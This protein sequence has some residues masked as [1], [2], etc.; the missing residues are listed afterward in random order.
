MSGKK[1]NINNI[2]VTERITMDAA[3]F[4]T[5]KFRNISVNKVD[6]SNITLSEFINTN[7]IS[8]NSIGAPIN[9]DHTKFTSPTSVPFA[10][11]DHTSAVDVSLIFDM[12]INDI[13]LNVIS[14][15]NNE[16]ID[17]YSDT[18]FNRNITCKKDTFVKNIH[19]NNLLE[20]H[21]DVS[22]NKSIEL[23]K[24][25]LEI[26]DSLNDGTIKLLNDISVN[27]I[28]ITKDIS[29]NGVFDTSLIILDVIEHFSENNIDFNT[30]TNIHGNV[31]CK[32]MH[33]NEIDNNDNLIEFTNNTHVEKKAHISNNIETNKLELAKNFINDISFNE[34]SLDNELYVNNV[35]SYGNN[36]I[37]IHTDVSINNKN[38]LKANITK[39]DI[40]FMNNY[41]TV[42]DRSSGKNR[43]DSYSGSLFILEDE[44]DRFA[45][46]L[47]KNYRN[48]YTALTLNPLNVFIEFPY[49]ELYDNSYGT[50]DYDLRNYNLNH[51]EGYPVLDASWLDT[52]NNDIH[53]Y[54][55]INIRHDVSRNY[56]LLMNPRVYQKVG[57]VELDLSYNIKIISNQDL[58]INIIADANGNIAL[59]DDISFIIT[60]PIQETAEDISINLE[61]SNT[62]SGNEP[63]DRLILQTIIFKYNRQPEW[64]HMILT[65]SNG[66]ISYDSEI[67]TDQS[68]NTTKWY[69]DNSIYGVEKSIDDRYENNPDISYTFNVQ[70]MNTIEDSSKFV[71][72][73]SSI[74]PEG[75]DVSYNNNEYEY[76]YYNSNNFN[77]IS[78]F[79]QSN[80]TDWSKCEFIDNSRILIK[81][82]GPGDIGNG[83]DM[84][85][86]IISKDNY[87]DR[88]NYQKKIVNIHKINRQPDWKYIKLD[89]V[90]PDIS[91]D[92]SWNKSSSKSYGRGI[93]LSK[94]FN[95]Y[96]EKN[97]ARRTNKNILTDNAVDI[98]SYKLDL[99]AIDFEGFGVSY[100]ILNVKKDLSFG[101]IDNSRIVIDISDYI[102]DNYESSLQLITKDDW[103]N[104][105]DP[106]S[107]IINFKFI[108]S[109]IIDTFEVSSNGTTIDIT[110]DT[111]DNSYSFTH[112]NESSKDITI[113]PRY[114]DVSYDNKTILDIKKSI[115]GNNIDNITIDDSE[116]I[117]V[118]STTSDTSFSLV[119][120]NIL[121]YRFQFNYIPDWDFGE[122][123]SNIFFSQNGGNGP[124]N[125]QFNNGV[126]KA[127]IGLK[128]YANDPTQ[129][130]F[131]DQSFN[132]LDLYKEF[133]NT[134]DDPN[135]DVHIYNFSRSGNGGARGYPATTSWYSWWSGSEYGE[136]LTAAGGGGGASSLSTYYKV[137]SDDV[138]NTDISIANIRSD[139]LRNGAGYVD[140]VWKY[141]HLR[142]A[143]F[144]EAYIKNKQ[145]GVAHFEDISYGADGGNAA[146]QGMTETSGDDDSSTG[147]ANL[148]GNNPQRG[149]HGGDGTTPDLS[150]GS[151]GGQA[152]WSAYI[153]NTDSPLVYIPGAP[154]IVENF[155]PDGQLDLP[156]WDASIGIAGDYPLII[157]PSDVANARA[158]DPSINILT[159][160][161]DADAT[162]KHKFYGGIISGLPAVPYSDATTNYP[163]VYDGNEFNNRSP[164]YYYK[165]EN[166][167]AVSWTDTYMPTWQQ[168][169][170][171]YTSTR[172]WTSTSLH[173]WQNCN[174][175][176]Y[177]NPVDSANADFHYWT[178]S[179]R[180]LPNNESL[181]T[182]GPPV[183]PAT[184]HVRLQRKRPGGLGGSFDISNVKEGE[185]LSAA[186]NS[187][188]VNGDSSFNM[189]YFRKTTTGTAGVGYGEE[190]KGRLTGV[191]DSYYPTQPIEINSN[192][193]VTGRSKLLD[194]PII[195]VY[196]SPPPS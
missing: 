178:N 76:I 44:T 72:D 171:S 179:N 111:L 143:G 23:N 102:F 30:K 90:N 160:Y 122:R 57:E 83:I 124:E 93:D 118:Q 103:I 89:I 91:L 56:K 151:R 36:T 121:Q 108:S 49:I 185:L 69:N 70:Y 61:I 94:Q 168:G 32:N 138:A 5:L 172:F 153:N 147:A 68:W 165:N 183:V 135:C 24:L 107:R 75:Y 11:I 105:V 4:D 22:A 125:I 98:S 161:D 1:A 113:E 7:N 73:L 195:L 71:L 127:V 164:M 175:E 152:G 88:Q 15:L 59:H 162:L 45:N 77:D 53:T 155:G 132:L 141:Y 170:A 101:F 97:L 123:I 180:T 194:Y 109:D 149:G 81:V 55:S 115:K 137:N 196:Y 6:L 16:K 52:D 78:G 67:G 74:D 120:D 182:A 106:D 142:Y 25:S 85:F 64:K 65:P 184:A 43:I 51:E 14:A 156:S 58:S 146:S 159:T 29:L 192:P 191:G 140:G 157:R 144:V 129:G 2:N 28:K 38:V 34:L 190:L 86:E 166:N 100:E 119:F 187:L 63:I 66:D 167:I 10:R 21:S 188:Q 117:I 9:S 82:P 46:I 27:K 60:T 62:T 158:Y 169:D 18:S 84:S 126:I 139:V 17:I 128:Y 39:S 136:I 41:N 48:N 114:N 26:I 31:L 186:L 181:G 148:V 110:T 193:N 96:F 154:N 54:E 33:I 13:S 8:L 20:I 177:F 92:I 150:Y 174:F 50:N 145:T 130:I 131:K 95:L 42:S 12:S 99:S 112:E 80:T 47:F 133:T 134:Y 176:I 87:L 79:F 40:N 35:T 3:Q 104:R 163:S 173:A 19:S 37:I 116:N 189:D